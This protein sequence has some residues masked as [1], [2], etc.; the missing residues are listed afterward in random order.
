MSAECNMYGGK[1]GKNCRSFSRLV[2][3]RDALLGS[4][5]R[6]M[7]LSEIFIAESL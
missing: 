2:C 5:G 1:S 4:S 3:S 7:I 6:Y